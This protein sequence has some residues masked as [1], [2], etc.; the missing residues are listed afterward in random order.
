MSR[1]IDKNINES[2]IA[3]NNH[4]VSMKNVVKKAKVIQM[5]KLVRKIKLLDKKK[6]TEKQLEKNKRKCGNLKE[7]IESIKKLKFNDVTIFAIEN[8]SLKFEDYIKKN[9]I[10]DIIA[11]SLARI[12][13]S[14]QINTALGTLKKDPKI[15]G[16]KKTFIQYK[17][18]L[19]KR[20]N[21]K[22]KTKVLKELEKK[23]VVDKSEFD[24][25]KNGKHRGR[26]KFK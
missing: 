2:L 21:W 18:R 6:G 12:A 19:E 23:L 25:K 4:I 26:E 16:W 13:L 5:Q 9:K 10:K 8:D 17:S 24:D 22:E 15:D 11:I 7:E 1:N 3:F 14:K 20:R